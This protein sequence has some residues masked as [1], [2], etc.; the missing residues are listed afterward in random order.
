ME[1]TGGGSKAMVGVVNCAATGLDEDMN[2]EITM[3]PERAVQTTPV[4]RLGSSLAVE[5]AVQVNKV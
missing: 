5:P 3:E 4:V 1:L 2:E